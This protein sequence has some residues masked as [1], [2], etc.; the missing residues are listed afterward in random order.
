MRYKS[1][2]LF[3]SFLFLFIHIDVSAQIV[4]NYKTEAYRFFQNGDYFN[5][6]ENYRH[7]FKKDSFNL[8]L[9]FMYAEACRN[10]QSYMDAELLYTHIVLNDFEDRYLLPL[11]WLANLKEINGDYEDAFVLYESFLQ[12]C[13][14]VDIDDWY[15]KKARYRI[16]HY[17]SIPKI[18][19]DTLNIR[20]EHLGM[21]VNSPFADLSPFPINDSTIYFSSIKGKVKDDESQNDELAI[22]RFEIYKALRLNGKWV[23][24]R[25]W[26]SKANKSNVH[27]G[28]LMVDSTGM[29]EYF[30]YCK[31]ESA[32]GL[33][34]E[35]YGRNISDT[36]SK[37]PFLIDS[38]NMEGYSSTHPTI[39][40][41]GNK[42]VLIFSSNRPG[43]KGN[44]DLW[45]SELTNK[46]SYK[47]PV[48]LSPINSPGNEITP[49]LNNTNNRIYFS[50][51]YWIGLGGYDVFESRINAKNEFEKVK[52]LG[53]PINTGQNDLYFSLLSDS[54]GGFL[55]S[56]RAGGIFM[57]G[58]MCCHDIYH[59]SFVEE[60]VPMLK[61]ELVAY[62]DSTILK[63]ETEQTKEIIDTKTILERNEL[64]FDDLRIYFGF[65]QYKLDKK[66]KK[67]LDVVA[68][69]INKE[70]QIRKI[71]VNAHTDG[72]GE[73]EYNQI[74]SMNRSTS[75]KDYLLKKGIPEVMME[76]KYYGESLPL[77]SNTFPD[78]SDNPEGRKR[79]RRVEMGF[80]L[81]E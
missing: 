64:I 27:R 37:T 39:M 29:I 5:A 12:K 2:C 6:M 55:A 60:Y 67:Q 1:L 22:K 41:Q 79:N 48:N 34:C 25:S 52:N 49:F 69:I 14:E 51:D 63:K 76:I 73:D 11:F 23:V 8:D 36:G 74:L 61:E 3:F 58:E 26:K 59:Y 44:M 65:D 18:L 66:L 78:G 70:M 7:A 54:M 42:T 20:F 75:V 80:E 28:N 68:D 17:D 46:G 57:N 15:T 40:R 47:M 33:N 50:S 38:V 72:K 71:W 77:E 31:S 43:G 53:F 19:E 16:D 35:I 4:K 56:N 62:Q 13:V 10:Y 30:T 32:S 24:D 21:D 45:S 9:A 81:M